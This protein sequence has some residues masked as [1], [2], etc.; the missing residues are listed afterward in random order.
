MPPASGTAHVDWTV[1]AAVYIAKV[2]VYQVAHG[3]G[4]HDLLSSGLARAMMGSAR[5]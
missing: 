2:A 1:L 3:S 4:G 5:P